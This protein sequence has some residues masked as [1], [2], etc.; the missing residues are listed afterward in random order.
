MPVTDIPTSVPVRPGGPIL[1]PLGLGCAPLGNLFTA[2]EETDAL[3]VVDAAWTAGIRYFDTAPLYGIGLSEERL[4]RA[5]L[6]RPRH[7]YVISTKVGR[8]VRATDRPDPDVF[9][10]DRKTAAVFDFSADGVRRSLEESLERL[11]LDHVDIAYVHDP[12]DH[13]DEALAGA[14][15]RWW[16]SGTKG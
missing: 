12:D 14:F 3:A 16:R 8:L 5:L 10:V 1:T 7:E 11:G 9:A 4:G 13:Q 15:P 2:V 6:G